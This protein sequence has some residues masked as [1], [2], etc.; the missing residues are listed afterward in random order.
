MLI[1][2]F[3]NL[4]KQSPTVQ[5]FTLLGQTQNFESFCDH[6]NRTVQKCCKRSKTAK[7]T[8]N[9]GFDHFRTPLE[10]FQTLLEK[11]VFRG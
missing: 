8:L 10:H 5:I 9:K 4:Y 3:G 7:N 6:Q 11:V 2:N 1:K